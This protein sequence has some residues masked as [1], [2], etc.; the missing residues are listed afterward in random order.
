MAGYNRAPLNSP[1]LTCG[2]PTGGNSHCREHLLWPKS[3]GRLR[4]R[5][6]Q[7]LRGQLLT[8]FANRCASCGAA[9]P[10]EMH[11]R[12]HNHLNN[13]M[14][15]LIPLCRSCHAKAGMRLF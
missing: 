8:A 11:H 4:G 13:A 6:G 14:S 7:K 5:A 12:D 15:N 3:P 10:L 9:G 2:K 1:C